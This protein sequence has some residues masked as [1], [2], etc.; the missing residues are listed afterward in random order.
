MHP[1][2]IDAVK[3]A[4]FAKSDDVFGEILASIVTAQHGVEGA[5]LIVALVADR[6]Q[7]F[8]TFVGG[9]AHFLEKTQ[10]AQHLNVVDE[11]KSDVAVDIDAN[12]CV[13]YVCAQMRI[14]ETHIYVAVIIAHDR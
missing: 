4:L 14:D 6:N 13:D 8:Q 10:L 3:I 2:Q 12:R 1:A 9:F 7:N 11:R 5:P